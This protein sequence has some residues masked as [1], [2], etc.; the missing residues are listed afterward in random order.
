MHPVPPISY[1]SANKALFEEES[2]RN[3]AEQA[4]NAQFCV[5]VHALNQ[6]GMFSTDIETQLLARR[7]LNNA[8]TSVGRPWCF[9]LRRAARCL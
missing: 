6:G 9:E 7:L 4:S 5:E 3:M 8:A 2:T 1:F